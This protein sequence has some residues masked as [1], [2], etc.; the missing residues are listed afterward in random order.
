M[1]VTKLALVLEEH[2]YVSPVGFH[3]R[4][5]VAHDQ[6]QL[7]GSG[8]VSLAVTLSVRDEEI[9][10]LLV[11]PEKDLVFAREVVVEAW[12]PETDCTRDLRHVRRVISGLVEQAGGRRHDLSAPCVRVARSCHGYH[13]STR[14]LRIGLRPCHNSQ[15]PT[16]LP[17]ERHYSTS[18]WWRRCRAT[19]TGRR[20][21]RITALCSTR[22]S[23]SRKRA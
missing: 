18:I 11:D 2:A 19:A 6:T 14:A 1:L 16:A 12:L 21:A 22:W 5:D 15:S 4:D 23:E 9:D 20:A 7:L 13:A 3:Q 17:R 10:E 8:E